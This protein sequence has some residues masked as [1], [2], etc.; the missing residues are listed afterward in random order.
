MIISLIVAV[1]ENGVIGAD[2]DLP[3][4]LPNDMKFFSRTTKGH[5][6]LMGRKNFESISSKFRPLPGRTNI[7][8]TRNTSYSYEGALV[9]HSIDEG[10]EVARSSGEEE[11][12]I[13]GGGEIYDQSM[14][15]AEKLYVTHVDANPEG[16]THFPD[17]DHEI[18]DRELIMHH[19]KDDVHNFSFSIYVYSRK[20]S[21]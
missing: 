7:V 15:R 21:I 20:E 11:L 1:G 13:I 10:I 9:A 4:H 6:V 2:G 5:H 8:V 17:I 16:D 12:F 3:W 18:W 14:E 19:E